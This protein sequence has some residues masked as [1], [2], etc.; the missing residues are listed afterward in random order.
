M[1]WLPTDNEILRAFNNA[2][3]RENPYV[4]NEQLRSIALATAKKIAEEGDKRCPYCTNLLL[5]KRQCDKC[6][7]SLQK[8]IEETHGD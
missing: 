4:W 7:Q 6:W 8:E 5:L 3:A 1:T 2:P